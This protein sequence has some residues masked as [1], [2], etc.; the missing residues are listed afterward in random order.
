ML[1]EYYYMCVLE[2]LFAIFTRTSPWVCFPDAFLK[3]FWLKYIVNSILY[4]FLFLSF[5]LALGIREDGRDVCL[6]LWVS[7]LKAFTHDHISLPNHLVSGEITGHELISLELDSSLHVCPL[8]TTSLA[9]PRY[10]E[11]S[12]PIWT[13]GSDWPNPE[14][15]DRVPPSNFDL[16]TTDEVNRDIYSRPITSAPDEIRLPAVCVYVWPDLIFPIEIW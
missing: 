13:A 12:R 14:T 1:A 11:G 10:N 6:S 5:S 4:P 3:H 16:D 7:W 2:W 15:I 8:C 9:P